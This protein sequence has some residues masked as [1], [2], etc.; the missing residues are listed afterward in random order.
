M[1]KGMLFICSCVFILSVNA[2]KL[3]PGDLNLLTGKWTG[4]LTYLDYTSNKPETIKSFLSVEMKNKSLYLFT[5]SY[6][7]EAGHGGVEEFQVSLDGT[8]INKMKILEF[9]KTAEGALK[10][11]ME[12]NGTDGNNNRPA[13]FHHILQKSGNKLTITKMVKFT[14]ESVFFQRNQFAFSR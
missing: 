13:V 7:G 11:V 14:G 12:E 2:Q 6:P 5:Y 9:S 1:K 8:Q 4:E 10:I 3:N